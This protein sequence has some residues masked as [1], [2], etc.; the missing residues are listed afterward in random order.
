MIIKVG[1]LIFERKVIIL[2]NYTTKQLLAEDWLPDD[3]NE[4]VKVHKV[5]AQAADKRL[6][7]LEAYRHE[8]VL[9][10]QINGH[11]HVQ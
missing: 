2:A 1:I 4:L 11:T 10:L 7:R 6:M 5:L 3:Y 8:K 9:K